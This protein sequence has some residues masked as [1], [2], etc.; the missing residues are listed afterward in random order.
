MSILSVFPAG[1]YN[2]IPEFTYTGVYTLLDDGD[3][4]W[5]IKFL[6]SGTLI[7]TDKNRTVDA[8]LV[9]GGGGTSVETWTNGL[10]RWSA[11]GGGGH[12]ALAPSVGIVR[13]AAYPIVIGAGGAGSF[14]SNANDTAASGGITTAFSTTAVG[15][16]GGISDINLGQID[17]TN[18]G[19]Y[20]FQGTEGDIYGRAGSEAWNNAAA[21]TGNGGGGSANGIFN[22][23]SGIVVIRNHRAA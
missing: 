20:E 7:L 1:P 15:G 23:G 5:R 16:E 13:N 9:G 12:H 8:F 19:V 22:G 4:D 17:G 2:P 6:T 18:R 14:V 21:N 10:F 11:K 3:G